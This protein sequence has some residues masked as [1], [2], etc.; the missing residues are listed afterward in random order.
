MKKN[1]ARFSRRRAVV[2]VAVQLL[3]LAHILWWLAHGSTISPLEPSEA[4]SFAKEG[5]VNAGLV[6]FVVAIA[7]TLIFGR[8][9]CGWGCHL[10]LLQ[11][12]CRWLLLKIGIRPRPFR[13]RTLKLVPVAA[14][15]YMFLWPFVVRMRLGQPSPETTIELSTNSFWATFPGPWESTLTLLV[16]GFV[17]VYL[18]GSKAYCNYA[19]PYGAILGAV[20][21][22]AIGRIQVSDACQQCGKCTAACSSDVRVHEEVRDFGVVMD[23]NCMKTMD[24][25]AACPND[26]L[27][28]GFGKPAALTK[29][30]AKGRQSK[31]GVPSWPEE[32]L[33]LAAYAFGFFSTHALYG[34]FPFL[35]ALGFGIMAAFGAL[36]LKRVLQR[37]DYTFMGKHLK[38]KGRLT[39]VGAVHLILILVGAGLFSHSLWIQ[40]HRWT[41]DRAFAETNFHRGLWLSGNFSIETIAQ[42]SQGAMN[43]AA[44]EA[45]WLRSHGLLNDDLNY[46]V[47]AWDAL[48]EGDYEGFEEGIL[49]VLDLRPDFGEVQMQYAYFLMNVQRFHD[50][51]LQLDAVSPRDPRYVDAQRSAIALQEQLGNSEDAAKRTEALEALGFD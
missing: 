13:S 41:R 44:A 48:F 49:A 10:L 1:H 12:F 50:A 26:A 40:S 27:S 45:T 8:Y 19:C 22:F 25:I 24:C 3:L 18:L 9:F 37:K 29:Q 34:R 38:R 2:L 15:V 7:A 42:E 36:T 33:L 21:N 31:I 16:A 47:Q 6:L 46:F 5:V 23:P 11:D 30:R 20:D 43:I 17:V 35:L 14:F 32:I 28:F 4:M 51:R 39:S